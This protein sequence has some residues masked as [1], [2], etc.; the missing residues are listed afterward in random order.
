[1][2]LVQKHLPDE[3]HKAETTLV[4]G[5]TL[6]APLAQGQGFKEFNME[7]NVTYPTVTLDFQPYRGTSTPGLKHTTSDHNRRINYWVARLN[8]EYNEMTVDIL[9]GQT[10]E[11]IAVAQHFLFPADYGTDSGVLRLLVHKYLAPIK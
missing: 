11:P 5:Y 1:M 6:E 10:L 3:V 9:N 8:D 7:Q 2:H 4:A